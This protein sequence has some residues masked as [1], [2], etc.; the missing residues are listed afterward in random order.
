M[1]KT[2]KYCNYDTLEVED[3]KTGMSYFITG[4][5]MTKQATDEALERLECL[6]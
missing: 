1:E 2:E 6:N 4:W 5:W 3:E